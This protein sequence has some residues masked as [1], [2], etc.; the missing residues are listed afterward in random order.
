MI[1]CYIEGPIACRLAC[2]GEGTGP[3][4]YMDD[5]DCNGNETGLV[6]CSRSTNSPPCYHSKDAGVICGN[7]T[8]YCS[9]IAYYYELSVILPHVELST[10]V[11]TITQCTATVTSE[12]QQMNCTLAVTSVQHLFSTS[13]RVTAIKVEGLAGGLGSLTAVLTSVLVGVALGWLCSCYKRRGKSSTW[14]R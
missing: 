5:T 12:Q 7:L 6:N 9:Y 14:E 2:F 3:I 8:L 13:P 11:N 4:H 10:V 1:L